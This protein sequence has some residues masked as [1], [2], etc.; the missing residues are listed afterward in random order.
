MVC[1]LWFVVCGLWL[2]PRFEIRA[3]NATSR[4]NEQQTT[5][6][7]LLFTIHD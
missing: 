2:L 6:H 7:K 1:G 3:I 4:M 5:N